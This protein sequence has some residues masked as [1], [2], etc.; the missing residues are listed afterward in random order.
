[1]VMAQSAAVRSPYT[2]EE[3]ALGALVQSQGDPS[4]PADEIYLPSCSNMSKMTKLGDFQ[5]DL[6]GFR[7]VKSAAIGTGVKMDT[8]TNASATQTC[9]QERVVALVSTSGARQVTVLASFEGEKWETTFVFPSVQAM[10]A[11]AIGDQVEHDA[12]S[13]ISDST[14]ALGWQ[15]EHLSFTVYPSDD[16]FVWGGVSSFAFSLSSFAEGQGKP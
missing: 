2:R 6:T 1:M 8:T 15:A 12:V 10:A 14:G 13:A 7:G 3:V 4:A 9:P 5:R 11:T 16:L